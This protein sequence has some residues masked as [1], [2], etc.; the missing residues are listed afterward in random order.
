[1]IPFKNC[2]K[3]PERNKGI[4]EVIESKRLFELRV[5]IVNP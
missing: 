4:S 1:L 3:S 5:L 2:L